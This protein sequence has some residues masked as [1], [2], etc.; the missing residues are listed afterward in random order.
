LYTQGA[1]VLSIHPESNKSTIHI[2]VFTILSFAVDLS[3][4]FIPAIEYMTPFIT[5][6][7]TAQS[8][9]MNVKYFII[10]QKTFCIAQ[11]PVGT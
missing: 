3:P 2:S 11:K 5:I 9:A 7:S 1:R 6:N 4:S 10:S 8:S